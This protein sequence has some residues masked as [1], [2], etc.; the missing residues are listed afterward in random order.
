MFGDLDTN[1]KC[2]TTVQSCLQGNSW[3]EQEN[4]ISFG[5]D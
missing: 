3:I 1:E 4:Q 2:N 5:L